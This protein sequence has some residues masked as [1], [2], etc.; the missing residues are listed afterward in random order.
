MLNPKIASLTKREENADI[1]H[2]EEVKLL[3]KKFTWKYLE[4]GIE[5]EEIAI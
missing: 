3:A 2:L 4:G 1:G 5:Y